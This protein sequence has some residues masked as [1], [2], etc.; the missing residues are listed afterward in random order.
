M[1]ECGCSLAYFYRSV[2]AFWL[3]SAL[4]SLLPVPVPAVEEVAEPLVAETAR[5]ELLLVQLPV[6]VLVQHLEH[7]LGPLIRRVLKCEGD[8]WHVSAAQLSG[9]PYHRL[10]S[11]RNDKSQTIFKP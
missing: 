10:S 6:I 11:R 9:Q 2:S 7:G 1:Q 4:C 5:H 8:P 3:I